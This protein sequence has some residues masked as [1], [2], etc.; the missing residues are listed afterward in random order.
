MANHRHLNFQAEQSPKTPKK[1]VA[2]EV[3]QLQKLT[4][5][6][7]TLKMKEEERDQ[8]E[9]VAD[10]KL[11]IDKNVEM[12]NQEISS[13]LTGKLKKRITKKVKLKSLKMILFLFTLL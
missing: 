11:K 12:E 10:G 4:E 9:L 5:D 2:F 8:E 7:V 3:D 13:S 6:A 1:T